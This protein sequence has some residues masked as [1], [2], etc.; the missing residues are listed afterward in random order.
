MTRLWH[1]SS[2][3]KD[4]AG[5]DRKVAHADTSAT[6]ADTQAASPAARDE[7]SADAARP[8]GSAIVVTVVPGFNSP[9]PNVWIRNDGGIEITDLVVRHVPTS[10]KPSVVE[11][12]SQRLLPGE[13]CVVGLGEDADGEVL[14]A[15][16]AHREG[17]EPVAVEAAATVPAHEPPQAA[18][19]D[20]TS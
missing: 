6:A 9:A 11:T 5:L 8:V 4:A 1:I 16:A 19:G 20:A 3:G 10:G 14:V 17:E 13:A 12:P 7:D 2:R 18:D 15:G